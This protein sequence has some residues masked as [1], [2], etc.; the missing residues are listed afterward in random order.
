MNKLK[1]IFKE[2]CIKNLKLKKKVINK[3][4]LFNLTHQNIKPDNLNE[5]RLKIINDIN[6]KRSQRVILQN[7]K[8]YFR[9]NF[10]K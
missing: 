3:K 5:F 6:K 10:R 2:I 4:N 7:F 1:K 8:T 9:C